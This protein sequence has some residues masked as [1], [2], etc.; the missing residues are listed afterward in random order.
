MQYAV[1]VGIK[2]F[3]ENSSSTGLFH[4]LVFWPFPF[5]SLPTIFS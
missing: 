1:H 5:P 2:A 3:L 4:C